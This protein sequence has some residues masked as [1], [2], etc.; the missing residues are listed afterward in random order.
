MTQNKKKRKKRK[1]ITTI[2]INVRELLIMRSCT[3][4]TFKIFVKYFYVHA[5]YRDFSLYFKCADFA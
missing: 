4:T 1:R 5:K 3:T 2:T